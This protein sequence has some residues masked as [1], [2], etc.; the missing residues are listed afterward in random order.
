MNLLESFHVPTALVPAK[1][2]LRLSL[3]AFGVVLAL[4]YFMEQSSKSLG[5]HD[6]RQEGQEVGSLTFPSF[7]TASRVRAY[8]A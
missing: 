1:A 2:T 8:N 3:V 6:Q 4:T 5:E 7:L